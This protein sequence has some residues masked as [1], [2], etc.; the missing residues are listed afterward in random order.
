MRKFSLVLL[1]AALLL[2]SN[3]A[4]SQSQQGESDKVLYHTVEFTN[5]T[6]RQAIS[7]PTVGGA[8][9][10]ADPGQVLNSTVNDNVGPPNPKDSRMG[11]VVHDYENEVDALA[12]SGDAYFWHV[13]RNTADLLVSFEYDPV[14]PATARQRA[15][16]RETPAGLRQRMWFQIQLSNVPPSP[17]GDPNF[18]DL[19][20]LETYGP[21]SGDDANM[22]SFNGD[23]TTSVWDYGAGGANTPYISKADI[24]TALKSDSISWSGTDDWV[25]VDALMVSKYGD[26]IIFSIRATGSFDGGELIV[27]PVSNPGGATFLKHGIIAN[28]GD[29]TT[30]WN[31]AFDL[32]TAFG[33]DTEEIDGIEAW[34]GGPPNDAGTPP[35][36]IPSLTTYGLIVLLALLLLSGII[37]IRRRRATATA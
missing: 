23:A 30:K 19:D 18:F 36:P 37:V 3:V 31:T 12:N 21:T 10:P 1:A 25:D 28:H 33:V 2:M 29:G 20:A 35:P 22:A 5:A 34:R 24:L 32:Q 7:A 9:G 11:G 13:V 6:D 14:D 4:W 16:F 26:S 17:P 8:L 27:M 15:V